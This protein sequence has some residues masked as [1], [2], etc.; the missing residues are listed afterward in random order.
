M[1]TISNDKIFKELEHIDRMHLFKYD[2]YINIEID[3][4][5]N[6]KF[7]DV[8]KNDDKNIYILISLMSISL[9]LLII[10]IYKIYK[11]NKINNI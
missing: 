1:S 9:I 7:P 8:F 6:L 3:K 4:L 5:N 10:L 2:K 11:I